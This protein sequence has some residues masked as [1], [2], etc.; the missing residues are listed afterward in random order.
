[1]SDYVE[2]PPSVR[3]RF[4]EPVVLLDALRSVYLM[5]HRVSE[6][7][8]ES[9]SGK[10]SEQTY[11]SFLNKLAQICDSESKQP[12][13]KTVTAIVVL[14]YGSIEYR[15][16]SNQRSTREL[17]TVKEYLTG[18]LQ[19]LADAREDELN[20]KAFTARLLSDILERVLAFNRPRIEGYLDSLSD[21]GRIDFCINSSAADGTSDGKAVAEALRSLVPHIN[22]ARSAP[23][24]KSD[25]FARHS[26]VLLETIHS[27]YE[28]CLEEYMRN[29]TRSNSSI[30][31]SPWGEVRHAVGRLLSYY[32]AIKVIISARKSWPQIFAN[33]E[34]TWIP[35]SEPSTDPPVIRRTANGIL[36]RM[37]RNKETIEAYQRHAKSLQAFGLDDRIRQRASPGRFRPIVH[38]EV[39]LL[40]SVLRDQAV[41][42]AE[43]DDPVRFFDEAAFGRYVGTSK[44]TC[45]L[46]RFY[47][48]AHPSGVRCRESHG[49]LYYNWRAPDVAVAEGPDA[50]RQRLDIL[51]SMIKDVRAE[52]SRAIR[53]RSYPRRKHDSRD[54]PTNP[55]WSTQ[56]GSS[57]RGGNDDDDL[58]SMMGQVNLDSASTR[59][60]NDS[61]SSRETTPEGHVSAADDDDE[62]PEDGGARL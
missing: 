41:A 7:D 51:E 32:I 19:L 21:E 20:D 43:G 49:N 12:L 55:L 13:G 25:E 3:K 47:F 62:D 57:V 2:L 35:S 16:A 46:C 27:H 15:L 4:Y 53:E 45:L 38:A 58:A 59:G 44:P 29:K 17:D 1:M 34:V 50:A 30:A 56:R 36:S 24:I 22:A 42:E 9:A 60:W 52:T 40:A 33:F 8:L 54:T 61:M 28:R 14:D 37:G 10:S 48:A 5:D 18:I 26:A 11:Y 31:D 6:P 23:R 39:N